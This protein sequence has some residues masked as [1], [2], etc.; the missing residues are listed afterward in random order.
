MRPLKKATRVFVDFIE[1]YLPAAV[2]LIMFLSFIINIIF[3]YIIRDPQNWSFE[4]SINSFV[5]IGLLGACVA[6]RKEDHVVFDL[7]YT[8]MKAKGQNI[9]R[10]I[11]CIIII[12]FCSI[13]IPI[14]IEYLWKLPA[15]TSILKI[16][17]YVVF[18][19]LPIMMISTVIRS[20]YRLIMDIKVLKNKT[21][22]QTYNSDE[23][24]ML[25]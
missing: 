11:T 19:P 25:I 2:F 20:I 8:R 6:Y 16:P 15:V 17:L 5:I 4:V 7:L 23:K 10:I 13:M 22:D 1:I 9:M 21:Y 18:A 3:R 24:E 14:S 12:V